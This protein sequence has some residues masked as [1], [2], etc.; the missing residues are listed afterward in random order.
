MK[1][2][3]LIFG[4]LTVPAAALV[5]NWMGGQIH[6]KITGESIAAIHY[7]HTTVNGLRMDNYPVN[8]KFFPALLFALLGRPR[9]LFAFLGGLLASLWI[10]D[11]YE[12]IILDRVIVP[13]IV[14]P[15]IGENTDHSR[16]KN[17][18]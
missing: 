3:R 8:T 6:F 2:L 4:F 9:W 7:V 18:N 11:R 5:G 13:L 14:N 17:G 15:I 12:A 10:D 1:I 16:D